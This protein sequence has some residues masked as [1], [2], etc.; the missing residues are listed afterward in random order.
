MARDWQAKSKKRLVI[1][2]VLFWIYLIYLSPVNLITSTSFT[3]GKT[4][5]TRSS[6][7]RDE[8]KLCK[9][10]YFDNLHFS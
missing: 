8:N 4:V 10:P 3:D 6:G 5:R 1:I 7:H 9:D 2:L